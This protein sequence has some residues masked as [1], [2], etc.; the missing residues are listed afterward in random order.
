MSL[1][2]EVPFVKSDAALLMDS[3]IAG[4][5]ELSVSIEPKISVVNKR[6]K[7]AAGISL[8][9]FSETLFLSYSLSSPSGAQLVRSEIIDYAQAIFTNKNGAPIRAFDKRS[10][11]KEAEEVLESIVE[12]QD[13]SVE[14]KSVT[15]LS[16]EETSEDIP[17]E[18]EEEVEDYSE[19]IPD[20]IYSG[21]MEEYE[22]AVE[23]SYEEA[24]EYFGEAES[25][26]FSDEEVEEAEEP[27]DVEEPGDEEDEQ[28]RGEESEEEDGEQ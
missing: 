11:E 21:D 10:I 27:I 2:G 19:F 18:T 4:L 13:I 22:G 20:D 8:A 23:P 5:E 3:D 28:E 9:S 15:V 14:G 12:V 7:E 1:T 17:E 26:T 25:Q 24:L 6:E 16:P